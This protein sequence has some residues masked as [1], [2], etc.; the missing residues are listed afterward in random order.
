VS[1]RLVAL[2]RVHDVLTR[3]SWEGANLQEIVADIRSTQSGADKIRANGPA[4][5]LSAP[6]ALSLSLALNE[7]STNAIKYGALSQD[8]GFVDLTWEVLQPLKV[9]NS[10]CIGPSMAGQL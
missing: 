8:N 3:E 4:V 2:A 1:R 7:L 9:R 10:F 5:W 6:L